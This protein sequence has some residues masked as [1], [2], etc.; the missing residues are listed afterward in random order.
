[1]LGAL[2]TLVTPIERL[3]SVC[4]RCVIELLVPFYVVALR[5]K[6]SFI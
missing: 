2:T 1:M 3:K 5:F 4:N 6:F